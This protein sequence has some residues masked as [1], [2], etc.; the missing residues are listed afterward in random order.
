MHSAENLKRLGIFIKTHG[1]DGQLILKLSYFRE[2]EL[3]EG[4]PVFIVIDGIPVPFFISDFRFISNDTAIVKLDEVINSDQASEFINCNVLMESESRQNTENESSGI[5][6]GI[7]GYV[8]VDEKRGESGILTA[9]I[10]VMEN[11][12]MQIDLDGKEVLVPYNENII[13]EI[14][15]KSKTILIS[16]P[17]GLIDLYL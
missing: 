13:K 2:D 3:N 1:I 10:G 15:H 12:V 4:E 17:E 16:A 11:P 7:E 8:I 5:S 14:N 9:I 6:E